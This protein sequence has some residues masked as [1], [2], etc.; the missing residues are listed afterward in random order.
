M[1]TLRDIMTREV[2]TVPP[3]MPL[4]ELA[5]LFAARHIGGVPVRSGREILGMASAADLLT[6]AARAVSSEREPEEASADDLWADADDLS[7]D[8]EEAIAAGYFSGEWDLASGSLEQLWRDVP[9]AAQHALRGAT[10]RDVM[11]TE[12]L[13]LPPWTSVSAAAVFM[14]RNAIHRVLVMD[15][16]ELHGIVSSTDIVNAVA[17]QRIG[18]PPITSPHEADFDPGWTHE[19]VVPEVDPHLGA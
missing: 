8:D 5:E 19:P 12:V 7:V 11:T 18:S 10:V 2:T 6:F 17:E 13:S 1:L 4:S 16:G 3:E 15:G 14:R 9:D